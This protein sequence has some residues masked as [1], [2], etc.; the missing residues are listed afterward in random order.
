MGHSTWRRLLPEWPINKGKAIRLSVP[1]RIYVLL[2]YE[3]SKQ[4]ATSP[5]VLA[6]DA[7]LHTTQA[8]KDLPMDLPKH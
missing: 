4:S 7:I 8:P 2:R 3:G 6:L 1:C 5:L